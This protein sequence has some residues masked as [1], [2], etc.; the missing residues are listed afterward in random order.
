MGLPPT[1]HH[2]K[3]TLHCPGRGRLGFSP[4]SAAISFPPEKS[5]WLPCLSSHCTLPSR[6]EMLLIWLEKEAGPADVCTCLPVLFYCKLFKALNLKEQAL[7]VLNN[8][9]G[10]SAIPSPLWPS[11]SVQK[12]PVPLTGLKRTSRKERRTGKMTYPQT[13]FPSRDA[14][15]WDG[16][17]WKEDWEAALSASGTDTARATRR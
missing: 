1:P 13:Y 16:K 6:E 4:K 12:T 10:L 9:Q 17:A 11:S 8:T 14:N 7:R 5:P 3:L 2:C 15:G